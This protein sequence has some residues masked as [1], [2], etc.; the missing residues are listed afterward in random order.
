MHPLCSIGLSRENHG[1]RFEG[2]ANS[3]L[4]GNGA[5]N[6]ESWQNRLLQNAQSSA[7]A[8][9]LGDSS[10]TTDDPRSKR[11]E[12]IVADG[13]TI[14]VQVLNEFVSVSSL[15]GTSFNSNGCVTLTGTAAR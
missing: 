9:C 13:R 6:L 4:Q 14:S 10:R 12:I 3:I 2:I 1:C 7:S 8:Q 15:V 11:A 5:Q